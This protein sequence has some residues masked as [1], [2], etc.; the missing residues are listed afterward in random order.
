MDQAETANLDLLDFFKSLIV[1]VRQGQSGEANQEMDTYLARLMV[2][3]HK[4]EELRIVLYPM[5]SLFK[6][7][8]GQARFQ[9]LAELEIADASLFT[10]GVLSR[11]F[12][13]HRAFSVNHYISIARHGYG[14][15]YKY[16]QKL[17]SPS[18]L[19]KT[20]SEDIDSAVKILRAVSA[21]YVFPKNIEELTAVWNRLTDKKDEAEDRWSPGKGIIILPL[22]N[23]PLVI[24]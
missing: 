12:K 19:Y 15:L 4:I 24:L 8:S 22:P 3:Y 23:Q 14:F 9:F 11:Q 17:K 6:E 16:T 18:P 5:T 21:Q 1:R 13:R 10:A 2:R 20:L 7:Y